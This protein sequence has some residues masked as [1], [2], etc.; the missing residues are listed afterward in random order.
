MAIPNN[1]FL[2]FTLA[3]KDVAA[4]MSFDLPTATAC[5]EEVG[6]LRFEPKQPPKASLVLSAGIHGNETAPI[7]M[8]NGLVKELLS[9]AIDLQV[10]LLVILGHPEAMVAQ[11]RFLDV[12]LNRLFCGA[13]QKYSG[14]EVP[15]AQVLERAVQAFFEGH[16]QGGK[17]HYD[18]HT[19]IRGS[20]YERFVVH[21]FPAER[22]YSAEQFGFYAAAG[23][24]AVLL[25][26]QPTTTFSYHSYARHGAEAATV[27]LGKVRPF[28]ENDFSGLM[29]IQ[30]ALQCLL[31][32]GEVK[33][34]TPEKVKVFEVVD[35]LVKDAEDYE[36]AIDADVN[37]FTSFAAGFELARSSNS[38]YLI[39]ATGDAIVFPNTNLPVG[40]R[41]GLVVRPI[42]LP[43]FSS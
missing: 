21:P 35:A 24:D 4:P 43:D 31:Q 12:N 3:H 8:V 5:L 14:M 25:S 20:Q 28:G 38:C 27:E 32:T 7:E 41:A 19:A 29:K 33:Q 23:I 26:H 30:T 2:G 10:R 22:S 36:L 9:G 11:K 40:Q 37:N 17:F 6:V 13:W 34:E 15:R 16:Q 1:D 39:K 18:L 42:A